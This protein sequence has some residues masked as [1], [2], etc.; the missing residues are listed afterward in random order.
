MAV[1]IFF[2][3][4]SAKEPVSF[5]D[6][7]LCSCACVCA[8]TRVENGKLFT[9]APQVFI[10][11]CLTRQVFP[12]VFFKENFAVIPVDLRRI[13]ST[14][15]INVCVISDFFFMIITSAIT[16]STNNG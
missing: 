14:S 6:Y 7:I 12:A 10:S 9:L 2:G 4:F 13:P 15:S 5:I 8:N 1:K 11:L 16:F 3:S